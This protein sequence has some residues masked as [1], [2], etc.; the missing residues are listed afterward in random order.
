MEPDFFPSHFRSFCFG[1]FVMKFTHNLKSNRYFQILSKTEKRQKWRYKIFF[2]QQRRA[3]VPAFLEN[4]AGKFKISYIVIVY[5]LCLSKI[6]GL[7][8]QSGRIDRNNCRLRSEA[9]AL[10]WKP[11]VLFIGWWK[12]WWQPRSCIVVRSL[13]LSISLDQF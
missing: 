1:P 6:T 7:S 10:R 5:I 2:R 8:S 13:K 11:L 3:P 9:R 4:V 12:P